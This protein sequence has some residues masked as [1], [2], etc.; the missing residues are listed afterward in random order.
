MD[1]VCFGL[2]G[3]VEWMRCG[4]RVGFGEGWMDIINAVG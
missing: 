3:R 2:E 4:E 1:G